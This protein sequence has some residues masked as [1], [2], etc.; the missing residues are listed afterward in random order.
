M[1]IFAD[2]TARILKIVETLDLKTK[3]GDAPDLSR[4]A[5]EAPRDPSHG[6]VACNAAMVLAKQVGQNP[7]QLAGQIADGLSADPDVASAEPVTATMSRK[8]GSDPLVVG[9]IRHDRMSGTVKEVDMARYRTQL[10]FQYRYSSP[11]VFYGGLSLGMTHLELHAPL[12]RGLP[13]DAVL[14]TDLET[15][16][17]AGLGLTAFRAYR[18]RL[19]VFGEFEA[20]PYDERLRVNR[21]GFTTEQ[22]AFNVRNYARDNADIT[23]SSSS[24]LVGSALVYDHG[25]LRPELV[26]GMAHESTVVRVT[27]NDDARDL[28]R[29]LNYDPFELEQPYRTDLLSPYVTAAMTLLPPFAMKDAYGSLG[30]R[31]HLTLRATGS[32]A[33]IGW[34]AS[35]NAAF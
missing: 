19:T 17:T 5:V 10:L 3:D 22:G 35:L 13:T 30:L 31:T 12:V 29:T 16:L 33:V 32:E 27:L 2:F 6:D 25:W 18:L 8:D 26:V 9:T 14:D 28:F 20:V 1:N 15:G 7:R 24:F 11:L 4:V 23:M 34:G 21:L